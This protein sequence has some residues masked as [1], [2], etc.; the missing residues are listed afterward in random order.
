[1]AKKFWDKEGKVEIVEKNGNGS[2]LRIRRVERNGR[3][4][5]EVREWFYAEKEDKMLPT[6]KGVVIPEDI[7]DDVTAL[8]DSAKTDELK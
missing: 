3:K 6:K 5:V 1:V 2:E 7:V 4:F 8:M